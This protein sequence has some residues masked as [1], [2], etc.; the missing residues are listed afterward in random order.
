MKLPLQIGYLRLREQL[1]APV[2]DSIL[3]TDERA[4]KR[5]GD[6]KYFWRHV[7]NTYSST[8]SAAEEVQKGVNAKLYSAMILRK[9]P[10][11]GGHRY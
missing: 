6:W 5:E 11:Q 9:D 4:V 3:A 1:T 2:K 7:Q 10:R 8:T